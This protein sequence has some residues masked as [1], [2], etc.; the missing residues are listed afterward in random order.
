MLSTTGG[1]V[2]TEK[3][4]YPPSLRV[5]QQRGLIRTLR[6][7]RVCDRPQPKVSTR[8]PQAHASRA[9]NTRPYVRSPSR[10]ARNSTTALCRYRWHARTQARTPQ[11]TPQHMRTQ[12]VRH[13]RQP[14]PNATRQG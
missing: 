8:T 2:A 9:H 5:P 12:D 7:V 6:G 13:A 11:A 14:K 3:R 4:G 1:G 10:L